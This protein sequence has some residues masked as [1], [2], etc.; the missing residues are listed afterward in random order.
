MLPKKLVQAVDATSEDEVALSQRSH[1]YVLA[2]E[3]EGG[4][5]RAQ[6]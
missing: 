6:H 1:E 5:E 2:Q 3:Q 4:Q